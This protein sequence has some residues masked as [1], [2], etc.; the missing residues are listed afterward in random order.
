METML[1]EKASGDK[2]LTNTVKNRSFS[3]PLKYVRLAQSGT[4]TCGANST[5]I[6]SAQNISVSVHDVPGPRLEQSESTVQITNGKNRTI[7]CTA[8][9]PEASYVD[10]FWLFNGSRIQTNSKYDVPDAWPVRNDETNRKRISLKIYNAEITDSGQYDCV[11]NTS[12]GLRLQ[13]FSVRVIP[14]S[15]GKCLCLLYLPVESHSPSIII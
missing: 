9:Y 10:T 6:M 7:S 13:N 11:L 12:H 2:T 1:L 14:D 8:V 5:T 3:W 15:N 4:Y